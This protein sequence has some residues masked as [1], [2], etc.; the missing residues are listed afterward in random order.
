MTNIQV[1][2]GLRDFAGREE[3]ARQNI[4]NRL[5]NLFAHYGYKRISTPAIEYYSTYQLGY[6]DAEDEVFYKFFDGDGRIL[7]LRSDM[8]IPIARYAS[9]LSVILS[10]HKLKDDIRD[11]KFPG[12]IRAFLLL[13]FFFRSHND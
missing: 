1:P 13:P 6:R 7:A 3:M 10:Y 4:V 12:R 2:S 8:T 5:Q 9:A 11:S